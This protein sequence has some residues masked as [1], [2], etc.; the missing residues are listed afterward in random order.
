[1][2]KTQNYGRHL[3]DNPFKFANGF[4]KEPWLKNMHKTSS[5]NALKM[6]PFTSSSC[7]HK[8]CFHTWQPCCI[9]N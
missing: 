1:M 5:S 6:L 7:L 2:L 8:R 4:P 3:L 9:L